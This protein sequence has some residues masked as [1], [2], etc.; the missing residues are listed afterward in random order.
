[1]SVYG[2]DRRPHRSIKTHSNDTKSNMK[3]LLDLIYTGVRLGTARGGTRTGPSRRSPPSSVIF[4]YARSTSL[5]FCFFPRQPLR[6]KR[7]PSLPPATLTQPLSNSSPSMSSSPL[8]LTL[9]FRYPPPPALWRSPHRPSLVHIVATRGSMLPPPR[10][11]ATWA[12]AMGEEGGGVRPHR[13]SPQRYPCRSAP[14]ASPRLSSPGHP[15]GVVFP[16]GRRK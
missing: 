8:S 15:K 9:P 14:L 3:R 4:A 5:F 13:L 11:R 16:H 10:E 12:W 2:R 6:F 1:M 7:V